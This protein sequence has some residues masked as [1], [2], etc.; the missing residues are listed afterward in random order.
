MLPNFIFMVFLIMNFK[1]TKAKL[2]TNSSPIVVTFYVLIVV[3]VFTSVLRCIVSMSVNAATIAGE[4][5]D[6]ILWVA[7][8]FFLLSMEISVLVFG[9]AFGHLDSRTSI[10]RVLMV[11]GLLSFGY[12]LIQG[13]LEIIA[14]DERFY[15]P[16]NAGNTKLYGHGGMKFWAV[17]CIIFSLV[18]GTVVVLPLTPVRR[19][20]PLPTKKSFY[21]YCG[22][23][24]FMNFFQGIGSIVYARN[25]VSGLCIIDLSTY[26]Y[27][28]FFH[29]F[30]YY[31]FLSTFFSMNASSLLFNYKHQLDDIVV[32]EPIDDVNNSESTINALQ[33][34]E[35][36]GETS[37]LSLKTTTDDGDAATLVDVTMTEDA[38]NTTLSQ[39][40]SPDDFDEDTLVSDSGSFVTAKD[41]SSKSHSISE[42]T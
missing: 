35:F 32:D 33:G 34:L 6:K 20:I 9:L 30:V 10:R 15:A 19:R 29:I 18:Y 26:M 37:V 12:S 42:R 11:T 23:L 31:T 24:S 27:F 17:T 40:L 3:C 16:L 25:D 14:P 8:R 41:M 4:R 1:K 36:S 13:T 39:Y 38:N 7:V 22:I 21:I 28:S 2:S 5:T